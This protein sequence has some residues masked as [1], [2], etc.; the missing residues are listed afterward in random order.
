MGTDYKR[1]F[2]EKSDSTGRPKKQEAWLELASKYFR[3]DKFYNIWPLSHRVAIRESLAEEV[4]AT[5]LDPS[6]SAGYKEVAR[7]LDND[8]HTKDFVIWETLFR[9][10]AVVPPEWT[11]KAGYSLLCNFLDILTCLSKESP[12][13]DKRAE[14]KALVKAIRQD[15]MIMSLSWTDIDKRYYLQSNKEFDENVGSEIETDAECVN[16]KDTGAKQKNAVKKSN[17]KELVEGSAAE[18][19]KDDNDI[20]ESNED[21]KAERVEQDDRIDLMSTT[22]KRSHSDSV[23]SCYSCEEYKRQRTTGSFRADS[24][25]IITYMING[26]PRVHPAPIFGR[27]VVRIAEAAGIDVVAAAREVIEKELMR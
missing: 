27:L 4:T 9:L 19:P 8:R 17:K 21:E 12:P 14:L 10:Q 18:R 20:D 25:D 22:S 5:T 11:E 2:E 16:E 26:E 6:S 1:A 13:S 3:R 23:D 15:E 7:W 24:Y